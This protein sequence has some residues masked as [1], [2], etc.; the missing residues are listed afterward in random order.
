MQLHSWNSLTGG[1]S[2][3][4]F[5]LLPFCSPG[6]KPNRFFTM[7]IICWR[8]SVWAAWLSGSL[9]FPFP[10]ACNLF[11]FSISCPVSDPP[12]V[13]L[14][15]RRAWVLASESLTVVAVSKTKHKVCHNREYKLASETISKWNNLLV[16]NFRPIKVG[17]PLWQVL[18]AK[19]KSFSS[20]FQLFKIHNR[21]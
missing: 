7:A 10:C 6:F 4:P 17:R 11:A 21:S 20:K 16:I 15:G 9:E 5:G 13:R 2:C 18:I 1:T 8:E 19:T 14:L 12:V 3:I